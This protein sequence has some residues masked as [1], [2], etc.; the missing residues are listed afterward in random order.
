MTALVPREAGRIVVQ[1]E[2]LPT[3][4]TSVLLIKKNGRMYWKR[5]PAVAYKEFPLWETGSWLLNPLCFVAAEQEVRSK[6]S[7]MRGHNLYRQVTMPPHIH[8]CL[9]I[10]SSSL[11]V[12]K[13]SMD[14]HSQVYNSY[15]FFPP[16]IPLKLILTSWTM[17]PKGCGQWHDSFYASRVSQQARPLDMLRLLTILKTETVILKWK[18]RLTAPDAQTW[19]L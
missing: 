3:K 14:R 17:D 5:Q 10:N 12:G 1:V 16:L 15:L 11:D 9:F 8:T 13:S 6:G 7:V 19:P 4:P 18:T 2:A